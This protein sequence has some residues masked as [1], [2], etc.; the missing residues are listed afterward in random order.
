MKICDASVIE[1]Y[2]CHAASGRDL[3][4]RQIFCLVRERELVNHPAQARASLQ[5]AHPVG[6]Y[7]VQPTRRSKHTYLTT[8]AW[9]FK[10][11]HPLITLNYYWTHHHRRHRQHHPQ[12]RPHRPRHC[13]F[14]RRTFPRPQ[15]NRSCRLGMSGDRRRGAGVFSITLL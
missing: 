3:H 4:Q 11:L 7:Q 6:E 5:C 15:S 14:C 12:P 9:A 13:H 8:W 1:V 2:V 10:G